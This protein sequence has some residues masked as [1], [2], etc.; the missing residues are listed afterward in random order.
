MRYRKGRAAGERFGIRFADV[1]RRKRG[2]VGI[3]GKS[4][5]LKVE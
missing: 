5:G 1:N 2:K 3:G 4:K